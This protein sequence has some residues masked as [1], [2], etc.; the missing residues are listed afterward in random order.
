MALSTII[1]QVARSSKD[2]GGGKRRAGMAEAERRNHDSVTD[3]TEC[4]TELL[5]Y[6]CQGNLGRP[7][8]GIAFAIGMVFASQ[9]FALPYC[10]NSTWQHGHYLCAG[11]DE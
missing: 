2:H 6:A 3:I 7:L 1:K 8:V 4:M 9:A 10:A 11:Y 5:D